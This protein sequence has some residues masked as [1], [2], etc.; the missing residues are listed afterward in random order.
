M[1]IWNGPEYQ[2]LQEASALDL[3]T[4]AYVHDLAAENRVNQRR[5]VDG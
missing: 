3:E 4:D 1:E 5:P 2:R